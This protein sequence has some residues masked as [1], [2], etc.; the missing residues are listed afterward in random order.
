MVIINKPGSDDPQ[1]DQQL[2]V[3]EIMGK[4]HVVRSSLPMWKGKKDVTLTYTPIKPTTDPLSFK[5]LVE[6]RGE[7][8]PATSTPSSV[9]GVDHQQGAARFEWRGSGWLKIATSKWELIGYGGQWAVSFFAKTLF[10]PAGIDILVRTPGELADDVLD[11]IARD[12]V[13]VGGDVGALA[14]GLFAVPI[15]V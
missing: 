15:S 6:Y 4:W 14:H 1:F 5:D 12:I 3:E 9:K 2:L 11:G 13:A 8:K 10:T 7:G